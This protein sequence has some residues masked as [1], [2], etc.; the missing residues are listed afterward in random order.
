MKLMTREP[1]N[2][3][4]HFEGRLESFSDGKLTLETIA[5]KKPK[6]GHAQPGAKV[7]M[8]WPTLKR[9][10]WCRKSEVSGDLTIGDPVIGKPKDDRKKDYGK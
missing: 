8:S 10:I 2:G 7:Q 6:P 1:V 4:R 5:G 9:P 3:N